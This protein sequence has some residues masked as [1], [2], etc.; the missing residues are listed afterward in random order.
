MNR[1][2]ER[3]A[4]MDEPIA[5]ERTQAIQSRN[6]RLAWVVLNYAL[7]ADIFW[8]GG[9]LHQDLAAFADIF[10]IWMAANSFFVV[11]DVAMER[12]PPAPGKLPGGRASMCTARATEGA[13]T[14][15]K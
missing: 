7:G 4:K 2:P 3:P 5:D 12:R 13:A 15:T 8:R 6:V 1:K 10:Y 9:I 11:L 14:G